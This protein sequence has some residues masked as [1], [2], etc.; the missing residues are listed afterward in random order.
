MKLFTIAALS[1]LALCALDAAGSPAQVTNPRAGA[2]PANMTPEQMAQMLQQNPQLG[3][4]IRQQLQQSGL[5]P[6]QIRQQLAASGYPDN[7]LD[8]F[9]TNP[10]EGA[11]APQADAQ[12]LAALQALGLITPRVAAA[13]LQAD[14]GL[15]ISRAHPISAEALASG[16]YVFGVDVFGRSTTQFLPA[17]A[18][19]VPPDYKVGPGD[20]LVLILTGGIQRTSMLSVSRQGFILIPEVGQVFVS[21]LTIEQLRDVLFDRLSKVYSRLGRGP[22]A[23]I[24]FDVSVANVRVN[25]IAVVGEVQQPGAYNISALGS[26]LSALYAAGG[27]TDRGNM[28]RIEI[29]RQGRPVASLDLYDY[30]LR[31]DTRSD[32][33]L[34]SGDVLFVPLHGR[35]VQVTG[36]VLR[37][38][39]YELAEAETLEDLLRASGGFRPNALLERLTVY[40]IL[41]PSARKPGPLPR[42]ALSIPL[43]TPEAP[44]ARSGGTTGEP[45]QPPDPASKGLEGVTVPALPLETGDS[46]VVDSIGP[47]DA[48]LYVEIGGMVQKPGRYPWQDGMTLRDLFR[49]AGGPTIGAYLKDVEIARLPA[50]RTQ[51]QLAAT[52]RVP[53]DSTYLL[54]RDAAGR[55]IGPAGLSFPSPGAPEVPLAPFDNVLILKQPDFEL[56]RTVFIGG[57]VRSPGTY[58]LHSKD[59]RL[60]DLIDR[61]GGLTSQAYANGIRFFRKDGTTGA[62]GRVAID[63]QRLLNDRK[64]KD[65]LSLAAGDSIIIPAYVPTVL[66]RGEV[67]SPASV[68]YVKGQGLD[69]YLNA[70]GGVSYKGDKGRIYVQQPNGNVQA[71]QKR[72]LFFGHSKPTPEPGGLVFVPQRNMAEQA[73]TAATLAAIGTIIASLTTIVVVLV[74]HP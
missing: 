50:E 66:V 26:A 46:V 73:N 19:P 39:I 16:N 58:A 42:A 9:L 71:V 37:P 44:I 63:L 8:E 62:G 22:N 70:A 33:R 72:G 60:M 31:G 21:N 56:Q 4:L 28:R 48:G 69:Y 17:L 64:R 54:Q 35:R 40:R 24:R 6:E 49:L 10:Q 51:G 32:V 43:V 13:W 57:E 27:V 5:T 15:I 1:A 61:A 38:A 23:S 18:G 20:Q 41:P 55:Y 12:D 7:L 65:N 3:T 11:A 25:Q 2:L 53:V 36:A 67:N 29:R 34:E 52:V 68:T 14:T 45:P 59:E 30:L 74:N 47:L